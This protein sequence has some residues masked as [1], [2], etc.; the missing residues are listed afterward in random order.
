MLKNSRRADGERA[1][2]PARVLTLSLLL[3]ALTLGWLGYCAFSSFSDVARNDKRYIRS[4]QLRGTIVHLDEVLTMS[5]SL[6]ATTGDAKWEARYRA[7][8]GQLDDAIKAAMREEPPS[9]RQARQ[10]DAAN[11][12]LV[13]MEDS[14][15]E[16]VRKGHTDRARAILF[17]PFYAQQKAIYAAAIG[18]YMNEAS[19]RQERA[20]NAQ[21]RQTASAIWVGI[22]GMVSL[23]VGW[24][25]AL[26][27]LRNWGESQRR[28]V[29]ARVQA[30]KE[31]EAKRAQLEASEQRYASMA[32]N[33]P[34]MVYQLVQKADGTIEMPFVSEGAREL[35]GL[36]PAAICADPRLIIDAVNDE[37]REIL[38]ALAAIAA[39]DLTP[40]HWEGRIRHTDGTIRW[41]RDGA[42]PQLLPG[43]DIIW[44]CLTTDITASKEYEAQLEAARAEAERANAAKSEFLSRMSHELRTPL[45][46]VLGFGQLLEVDDPTPQQAASIEQILLAGRH[47]LDLINEVLDIARIESGQENLQLQSLDAGLCAREVGDLVRPLARENAVVFELCLEAGCCGAVPCEAARVLADA[48]RLKQI[49]LNLY[50]NAIKYAGR[51]A[52][53]TVSCGQSGCG[54]DARATITVRDNGPGIA[55]ALQ[56]RIWTPFDRIGAESSA[57]QGS[58]VGLPLARTL[59]RAMGGDLTLWSLPGEGCAFTLELPCAPPHDLIALEA[60]MSEAEV[61]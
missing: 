33:V 54:D 49:L 35:H 47:L 21:K 32:A 58:G 56:E 17:S 16:Q 19:A 18:N 41:V 34:G 24:M 9:A 37:D 48:Q 60:L 13:K 44:D 30:L 57:T 39:R 4:T 51:G 50:S 20:M 6:A 31:L 11:I 27:A 26:R 42:R 23:S 29:A 40:M 52:R 61:Y 43:G 25:V 22:V 28:E 3:T 8:E 5:A 14:A 38:N 55:P 1:L 59:A 53:V 36:G 2:Y 12:A 15:F 46:A 10:L 7:H 45:N